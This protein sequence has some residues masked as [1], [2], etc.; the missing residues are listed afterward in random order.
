VGIYE[1]LNRK[2]FCKLELLDTN[3]FLRAGDEIYD[4]LV[5]VIR[6]D[7][8]VKCYT[9][10]DSGDDNPLPLYTDLLLDSVR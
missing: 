5:T 1:S 4:G 9:F 2:V 6:D 3:A 8:Q 10:A 7:N